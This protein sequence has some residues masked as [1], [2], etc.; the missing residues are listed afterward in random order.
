MPEPADEPFPE[1][2]GGPLPWL[3]AAFSWRT[4][5]RL[6]FCAVVTWLLVGTLIYAFQRRLVFPGHMV[7]GRPLFEVPAERKKSL[8]THAVVVPSPGANEAEALNGWI[9]FR[10]PARSVSEGVS[11]G[12]P[13][14]VYFGGNGLHRGRRLRT[15]DLFNAIGADVLMVDYRGYGDNAGEPSEDALIADAKAVWR[16][17]REDLGVPADRAVVCGESLGGG[18]AVQL[19]ADASRR[20]EPPAG[21]VL[22]ATFASLVQTAAYHYPFLPV[23]L[24]L[25]DRFES[26]RA[27]ADVTCPILQFHGRG[28]YVVPYPHGRELF[29]AAPERSASGVA[30]R[31]VTLEKAGHNN[32]L[33]VD[34]EVY[35]DAN[36]AF[37]REIGLVD[38]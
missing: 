33:W 15:A 1:M 18:V 5:V 4:L 24:L 27:I 31:F 26:F 34:A 9:A 19:A 12:R 16:Y 6:G 11:A 29:A 7:G 37:L 36:A 2:P 23:R 14:V 22:R 20:G 30:K 38:E 21:L 25:A 13:L 28:D 10:E 3:H 32:I 8:R 35:Q 17:V